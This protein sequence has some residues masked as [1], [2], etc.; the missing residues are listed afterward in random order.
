MS[1]IYDIIIIGGGHNGL[2]A[3]AYLAKAGKDVLVL[4]QRDM[5]GG[6]AASEEIHPGFH[7]S[8]GAHDAGLFLPEIL[9]ELDLKSHG[10]E[11]IHSPVAVFA[12]QPDGNGLTLWR[13]LEKNRDEIARFS[14]ADAEKFLEFAGLVENL[15]EVLKS[16]LTTIPPDLNKKGLK[17][18]LPWLKSGLKLKRLG[19]RDMME[20]LRVLPMSISEFLDDWFDS[21]L[22]KGVLST[23]GVAG[24]RLGPMGAGTT[25][26]YLYQHA[27][28]SNG[29]FRSSRFIR[30]GLGKL[31]DALAAFIRKS[32]GEVR[33]GA[34]VREITLSD[35]RASGIILEDGSIMAAK[36]ILSNADPRRTFF[37]LLKP[38]QSGPEF[39][40][41]VR[42]IRFKGSTAKMNLALGGL[43][44][45][46]GSPDDGSLLTGH[47]MICPSMEYLER[48]YDETKYGR[49]S[50]QPALDI[51]IPS[52]LD[53]ALAPEGQ[54]VMSITMQY[55][56]YELRGENWDEQR[57]T[58]GETILNTL[59][60]CAPHIREHILYQEV[61]TPL[62]WERDYGL[63]EGSIYH[64]QMAL[65]QLLFMRPVSGYGKYRSPITNLYLC[66]AGTH[67]GGG[68]TGAPGYN[69]AKVVLKEW[70]QN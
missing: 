66:G 60:T 48:A 31:S 25:Y 43:P 65:D 32:G 36:I 64:G 47:I 62:D 7:I 50:K 40:N 27:G 9:E 68:V 70:E 17:E 13:D 1:A 20:F 54:H 33:C 69:A 38:W 21:D 8:S 22:L 44:H 67:P 56:P 30:G 35:D 6:A 28:R 2:V 59:S 55:A 52:L 42:N 19:K 63:T 5:L 11:I 14:E 58:L 18:L 12:P 45:F 23:A 57:E 39:V 49:F 3:A 29:G 24:T 46:A 16:T 15:S 34:K 37:D 51:V 26:N 61:I 10:L 41:K 53:P 4:E